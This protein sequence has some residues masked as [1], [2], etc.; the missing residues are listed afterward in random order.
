MD[1]ISM[2]VVD[3]FED[4]SPILKSTLDEMPNVKVIGDYN[5]LV[6]GYNAI[7]QDKPSVAI[8]DISDNEEYAL[9]VIEKLS[10]QAKNTIIFVT[11]SDVS[12]DIVLKTMRAGAREF[13]SKPIQTNELKNALDKAKSIINV[14][15]EERHQSKIITVFSNKGGI[16]KTTIA[17]NL[18]VSLADLTGKK[19]ALLDLNLQLGD[20]TTFLDISPSFDISYVVTHLNRVDES[21]LLSTLEKYKDKDLYILADPPYLE[22]AE[23]IT[24]EQINTVLS[25]LK[26]VFS[27]I[28]IDTSSNFDSKTLCSLDNSDNILLVSMVNLPTIRNSQRC[29]D[30]FNRLDYNEDKVKLIIN[31]YMPNEEI[32]VEDVE[33]ALGHSVY[34]KFPNNYLSVMSAINR[35]VPISKIDPNSNISQS[36]MELAAL[37][38]NSVIVRDNKFQ[39]KAKKNKSLFSMKSISPFLSRLTK[40]GK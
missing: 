7:I 10:I 30:L 1:L 4:Q 9:E 21:F 19:V 12:T 15:N 34:W 18:A 31:R 17:A 23:E 38:S 35:G 26:S 8:I 25:I 33:D 16:G 22:Q 3:S 5:T 28:I 32:T 37:L 27:Y 39:G 20:V 11:S 29:I 6:A 24:S 2:I 14:D 36:F 13:L 40:N